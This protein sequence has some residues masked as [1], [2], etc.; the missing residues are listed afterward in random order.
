MVHYVDKRMRCWQAQIVR[1][2]HNGLCDLKLLVDGH[3]AT[4]IPYC[5]AARPISWHR[6]NAA[7]VL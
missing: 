2:N 3:I 1:Q 7:C 4:S 5:A 6:P